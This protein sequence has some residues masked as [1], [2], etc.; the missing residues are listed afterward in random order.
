MYH[1]DPILEK[2]LNTVERELSNYLFTN[3]VKADIVRKIVGATLYEYRN[4]QM[5]ERHLE[6]R[7]RGYQRD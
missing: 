5:K 6:E 4:M 3:N 2:I 1:E 7:Q